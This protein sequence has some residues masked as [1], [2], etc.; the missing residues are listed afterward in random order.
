M[1]LTVSAPVHMCR[2]PGHGGCDV[3]E[4]DGWRVHGPSA[5][6]LR[7]SDSYI[8]TEDT[9]RTRRDIRAAIIF[10]VIAA[11]VELGVLFYFF[12]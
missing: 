5:R 11:T 12:R 7:L 9:S 6:R 10:G 4:L 1:K 2:S 3:T 8:V